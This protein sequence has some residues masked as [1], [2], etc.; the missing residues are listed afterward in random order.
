MMSW[1]FRIF[2]STLG[3]LLL[4]GGSFAGAASL[5]N[6]SRHCSEALGPGRQLSTPK[7]RCHA[8]TKLQAATLCGHRRTLRRWMWQHEK[9]TTHRRVQRTRLLAEE[10]R[11]RP[12]NQLDLT[13][14]VSVGPSSLC[15]WFPVRRIGR[16]PPLFTIYHARVGSIGATNENV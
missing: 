2:A 12:T 4:S 5:N 15:T 10:T 3:N 9:T 6:I 7:A 13:G 11:T 16:L 14:Q 8:T 1:K